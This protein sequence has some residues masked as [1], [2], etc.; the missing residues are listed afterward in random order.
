[1]SRW[2]WSILCAFFGLLMLVC[3]WVVPAHLRAVDLSVLELA[4]ARGASL[5]QAGLRLADEGDVGAARLLWQLAREDNL[6]DQ[7]TLG[8]AV[9]KVAARHPDWWFLGRSELGLQQLLTPTE[10]APGRPRDG[11]PSGTPAAGEPPKGGTPGGA[12]E[13]GEVFRVPAWA[14][15]PFTHL[16]IGETNRARALDFL[17]RSAQPAVQELLRCR[18]LTNTVLFAPSSSGAGQAL[19]GTIAMCGLLLEQG[20]L[21]AGLSSAVHTYATLAN[22]GGALGL[23]AQTGAV[24]A[25]ANTQPLEQLLLDLMSLGQRLNWDQ[26]VVFLRQVEDAETLRLLALEAR[27]SEGQLPVLFSAVALSGQ[28]AAVRRYLMNYA[29]SGFGDLAATLRFGAGGVKELLQRDERAYS[30]PLR[31]RL[32]AA[33]PLRGFFQV[34][35]EYCYLTPLLALG[36]KWC[37]YLL[38][39]F[40]LAAA[41]H[42]ARPRAAP[43]EEPLQVRGAHVARELLFALGFL[44]VVLLL[45]EPF[46]SQES[47]KVDFPFRLRLPTPG[48]ASPAATASVTSSFMNTVSLLTMLTFFVLQG[49]LYLACLLKL[50]EIDRQR[51]PARMKVKLLENEDHLFDAGLYLGFVGTIISFMLAS[52]R[53][54]QF[55]SLMT[56]YSSTSFGIIFVS[57]FKILHLR[58]MRRRYLLEAEADASQSAAAGSAPTAAPVPTPS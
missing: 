14:E 19:D 4:G 46:L 35:R 49:V 12:P 24:L 28:P 34:T 56:A 33:G 3:G 30:S 10:L 53:V 16:F 57:I 5:A 48:Q 6:P 11:T 41:V 44:L 50:A 45:S 51:V 47:Q 27:E 42:F 9:Q 40:L 18:A 22:E 31:F 55:P 52:L 58:P 29:Q 17:S 25:Q 26:L 37:F 8:A 15:A 32:G 38:S 21:S 54:V 23:D 2:V 36:V 20:R 7:A 13:E 43:L 39:G 1:M